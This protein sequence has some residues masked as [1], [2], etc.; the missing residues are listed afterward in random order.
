M[1]ALPSYFTDFLSEIRPTEDQRTAYQ[2][3]HK[4]LRERLAEDE[5][6]K[7]LLITTFL[8]G[9]YRRATAVRPEGK[10]RP[11]VDVIVVTNID[12]DDPRNTPDAAVKLFLTFLDRHYKDSYERQ[13]RSIAITD[14]KLLLTDAVKSFDT[15]EDVR[16][17]R[18]NQNWLALDHRFGRFQ[19]TLRKSEEEPEQKSNPLKIPDRDLQCWEDTHPLEQIR[20]TWEKNRN[21][22]SHFVNVVKALKWWRRIRH[23]QSKYPKGYPLEHIVGDCCP[24]GVDTVAEGVVL[25]L[26]EITQRYRDARQSVPFLPDRGVPTHNVLHRL[27]FEDFKAFYEHCESAATIARKAFDATTIKESADHWRSLFG[28]CFPS[29]PDESN[30]PPKGGYTPRTVTSEVT[31]GRFA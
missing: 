30:D 4:T 14:G 10:H 25:T 17:W 5:D 21:T 18:L 6:T 15:P 28:D 23:S 11:D 13:N 20:W 24:D 2:A 19:E 31:R 12:S 7:N 16:D 29:A 22:N 3:A 1:S 9:S 27:S 8:Q 26:E